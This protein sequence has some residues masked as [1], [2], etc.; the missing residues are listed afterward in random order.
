MTFVV[1]EGPKARVNRRWCGG[2]APRFARRRAG[3]VDGADRRHTHRGCAEA[4]AEIAPDRAF[5][6]ELFLFLA[7]RA[8]LV[9]G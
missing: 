2:S 8:D 5:G 1:V 4:G 9:S 3:R 7:A 6:A